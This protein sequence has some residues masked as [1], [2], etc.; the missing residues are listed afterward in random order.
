MSAESLL[1]IRLLN[2]KNATSGPLANLQ[3]VNCFMLSCGLYPA[4][5][6]AANKALNWRLPLDLDMI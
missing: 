2:V 4:L 3:P 5:L 6:I 1:E